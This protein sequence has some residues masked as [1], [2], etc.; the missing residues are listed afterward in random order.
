M[1]ETISCP[2][3]S[4]HEVTVKY[5]WNSTYAGGPVVTQMYKILARDHCYYAEHGVTP[6]GNAA[7]RA[8]QRVA[9]NIGKRVAP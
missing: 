6:Y 9:N 4:R 1:E 5:E 7:V 8:S 3:C 2:W